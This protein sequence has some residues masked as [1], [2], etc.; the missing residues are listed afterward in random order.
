MFRC[1]SILLYRLLKSPLGDLGA[2]SSNLQIFKSIKS[3][4]L[5]LYNYLFKANFTT[6]NNIYTAMMGAKASS[7]SN[8][9][10]TTDT[11]SKAYTKIFSAKLKFLNL[12]EN[13]GISDT[14][15]KFINTIKAIIT[16]ALIKTPF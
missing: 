9:K 11:I 12:S 6:D 2:K 16:Q 13:I 7:P 8:N 15:K 3:S 4:N 5:K 10:N 14:N 1:S